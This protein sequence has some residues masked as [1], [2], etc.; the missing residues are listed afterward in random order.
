MAVTGWARAKGRK[1]AAAEDDDEE[2]ATASS[3]AATSCIAGIAD[4]AAPRVFAGFGA[5]DDAGEE[6]DRGPLAAE[7]EPEARVDCARPRPATTATRR[8]ATIIDADDDATAPTSLDAA[9]DA[10]LAASLDAAAAARAAS[11][12]SARE[13]EDIVVTRAV[14]RLRTVWE[15]GARRG[16]KEG[17]GKRKEGRFPPTRGESASDENEEKNLGSEKIN[18]ARGQPKVEN[19]KLLAV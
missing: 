14:L 5:E 19:E 7:E 11:L 3:A 13:R 4:A 17:R 15:R 9:G 2:E 16:G 18:T 1:V 6:V 12:A 10:P 8:G